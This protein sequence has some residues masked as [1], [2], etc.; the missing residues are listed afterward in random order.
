VRH[1]VE[2]HFGDGSEV[3]GHMVG[4]EAKAQPMV[5]RHHVERLRAGLSRQCGMLPGIAQAFADD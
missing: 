3:L 4:P 1:E 2:A 5:R